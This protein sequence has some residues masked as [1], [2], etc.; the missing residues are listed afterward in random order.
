MFH[1]CLE[2]TKVDVRVALPAVES[3]ATWQLLLL[4]GFDID[5]FNGD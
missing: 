5:V 1:V 3:F 4:A 2:E